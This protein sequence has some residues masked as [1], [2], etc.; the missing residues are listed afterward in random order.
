MQ[1]SVFVVNFDIQYVYYQQQ[2]GGMSSSNSEA[3]IHRYK[4]YKDVSCIFKSLT[5]RYCVPV[6]KG[7][8]PVHSMTCSHVQH[9]V[10]LHFCLF[11]HFFSSFSFSLQRYNFEQ[12]QKSAALQSQYSVQS[13]LCRVSTLYCQYSVQSVLCRVSTLYS[14]YFVQSVLCTVSTLYLLKTQYNVIFN[15]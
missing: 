4:V 8:F 13:V 3:F 1:Y 11:V 6:V 7:L 14:Q 9:I 10:V 12:L 2:R 5:T 15:I